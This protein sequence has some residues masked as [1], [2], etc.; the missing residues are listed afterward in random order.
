MIDPKDLPHVDLAKL[1]ISPAQQR[2][3][4]LKHALDQQELAHRY[5]TRQTSVEKPPP[6][7]IQIVKR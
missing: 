5:P 6:P 3:R 2:D 7:K 4:E 1:E